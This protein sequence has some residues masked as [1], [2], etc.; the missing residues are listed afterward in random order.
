MG[1]APSD[2]AALNRLLLP[3]PERLIPSAHRLRQAIEAKNRRMSYKRLSF[4]ARKD[5]LYQARR[6][7]AT[8][9][10]LVKLSRLPLVSKVSQKTPTRAVLFRQSETFLHHPFVLYEEIFLKSIAI[11]MS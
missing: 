6:F 5:C 1:D 11:R 10:F 4:R 8:H 7:R 3:R 2:H 9:F